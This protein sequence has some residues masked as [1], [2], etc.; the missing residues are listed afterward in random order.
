MHVLVIGAAGMVG[1]KLLDRIASEPDALGREIDK[2]TLVDVV[3]PVAPPSLSHPFTSPERPTF[4][5]PAW[6]NH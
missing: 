1:R 5:T 2:L 6:R 4:R 3:E